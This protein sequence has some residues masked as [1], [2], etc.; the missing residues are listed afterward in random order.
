M[1]LLKLAMVNPVQPRKSDAVAAGPTN[2][3][4]MRQLSMSA[5]R[6]A[7]TPMSR[8]VLVSMGSYSPYVMSSRLVQRQPKPYLQTGPEAP[9][10]EVRLLERLL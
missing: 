5:S 6:R 2:Q 7:L 10:T 4:T 9:P 3:R 8:L 1:Q